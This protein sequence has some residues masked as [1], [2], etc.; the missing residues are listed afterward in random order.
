M[1][2][3]SPLTIWLDPRQAISGL[4]GQELEWEA[5][6]VAGAVWWAGGAGVGA[7]GN[8]GSL[9]PSALSQSS[10]GVSREVQRGGLL[11]SWE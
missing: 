11:G 8:M 9:T 5:G 2:V 10:P 3:H 4:W 1:G 6:R 7:A